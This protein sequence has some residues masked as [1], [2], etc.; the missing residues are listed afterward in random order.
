VHPIERL[1]M[2]A[3][4]G[5]EEPS[6][7]AREAASALAGF[8]GEPA[9]LV[10]ACRRLVDRQPTCGPV[11]W[12]AARV[13]AAAEPG[14]EAWH[15]GDELSADPTPSALAAA[16]PDEATVV[17]VGW[18]EQIGDA[19]VR[20]GDVRALVVDALGHGGS[21][22]RWLERADCD[23][24]VVAESGTAA[25][26]QEADLVLIEADAL[27][28]TG[29]VAA[30]GSAAAAAVAKQLG[31]PVWAVAGLGR[32][33][34]AQLW[35]AL[36]VRLDDRGEPWQQD[37]EIVPLEWVDTVAGPQGPEEPRVALDRPTCPPAPE[38]AFNPPN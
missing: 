23:A 12:V 28:P 37:D 26:V 38:L 14:R 11:W 10:T 36:V 9:A 19:L 22:V 20:R 35:E 7:L 4:A 13:L 18:P 3:R 30:A 8:G 2:V 16:L 6:L 33:L 32:L 17:V 1:R 21:M 34:P 31:I 24:E 5:R 15:A 29:L 27:G 25:A